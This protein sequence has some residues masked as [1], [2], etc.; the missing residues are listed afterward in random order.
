MEPT[1]ESG[2]TG[3]K[4]GDKIKSKT[5]TGKLNIC[6]DCLYYTTLDKGAE[7]HSRS[8][9]HFV[10]QDQMRDKPIGGEAVQ[11]R[12]EFLKRSLRSE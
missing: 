2:F 12:R 10:F 6:F 3:T 7:E 8:T 4:I 1:V 9:K 5:Y 11:V